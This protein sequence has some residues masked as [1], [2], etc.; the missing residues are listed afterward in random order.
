MEK[1]FLVKFVIHISLQA[2]NTLKKIS[3]GSLDDIVLPNVSDEWA[4]I[5]GSPQ[6]LPPQ[7][8]V[9]QELIEDDES[10][11][12]HYDIGENDIK[13]E[14][15]GNGSH[16]EKKVYKKKKKSDDPLNP[17][18][19][20]EPAEP[21]PCPICSKMFPSKKGLKTHVM[22]KHQDA[23]T[24]C[25]EQFETKKLLEA[26]IATTHSLS[27]FDTGR[28]CVICDITYPKEGKH[29]ILRRHMKTEHN[30][31]YKCKICQ[32]MLPSKLE[33]KH[34]KAQEHKI[35]TK[36]KTPEYSNGQDNLCPSCGKSF[37]VKS[38]LDYHVSQNCC[39]LLKENKCSICNEKFES[40][41]LKMEHF[42][43]NHPEVRLHDC[44]KCSSRF[45]TERGLKKHTSTVHGNIVPSIC[46]ICGIKMKNIL[47][48]K[49]H[50][51]QVHEG[52]KPRFKC[53]LCDGSF[54]TKKI[55][56]NHMFVHEGKIFQCTNCNEEFNSRIKFERHVAKEHLPKPFQCDRCDSAYV[57]KDAL[58]QHIAFVH[59]KTISNLCPHCGSNHISVSNLKK[60]IRVVH[61]FPDRKPHKCVECGKDFKSEQAFKSHIKIIHEGSRVKCPVCQKVFVS[62][63]KMKRHIEAIHEKKRPHVCEICNESFAQRSNLVTHIKGKHKIMM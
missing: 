15:V 29:G 10:P 18:V 60:H 61:E 20:G 62:K 48:L 6:G 25:F 31:G 59:D 16:K 57:G 40:R 55:L 27:D 26:H 49:I 43:T 39:Y 58:V 37:K 28:R 42:S 12:N 9:K 34:H 46:P 63:Q 7:V 11:N 33:L 51:S 1:C 54:S 13:E 44:T 32:K 23:C 56:E 53:T 52:N 35:V 24:V 36:R 47:Y 19:K 3:D 17:K 8:L 50:I 38:S 22:G 4:Q 21:V 30:V 41:A 45:I 14:M 2:L 5:L